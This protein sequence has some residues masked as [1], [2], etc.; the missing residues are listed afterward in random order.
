MPDIPSYETNLVYQ[1]PGVAET[2]RM[3]ALYMHNL[4]KR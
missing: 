1:V 3:R 2:A 4:I